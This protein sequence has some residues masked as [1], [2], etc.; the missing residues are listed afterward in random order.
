[1]KEEYQMPA[2]TDRFGSLKEE[3]SNIRDQVNKALED[4]FSSGNTGLP[5]DIYETE[6][7]VVVISGPIIGLKTDLLD[8]SITEGHQLTIEGE[9][10]LPEDTPLDASFIRRE[11]KFG[12]FTRTVSIPVAVLAEETRASYKDNVLTI[13][14]PK[15][16]QSGPK[17]VKVTNI[18]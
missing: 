5:L 11:R 4:T 15:V 8:I 1:M 9:T 17:V 7:S 16:E 13:T 6:T 14:L 12:P 2:S 3:F 18:E 10:T